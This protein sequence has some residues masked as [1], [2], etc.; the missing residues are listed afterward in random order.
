[1]SA[2]PGTTG[3]RLPPSS[4]R[5]R[6]RR[7]GEICLGL[8]KSDIV[9]AT[10]LAFPCSFLLRYVLI[11][12]YKRGSFTE[13]ILASRESIGRAFSAVAEPAMPVIQE[14]LDSHIRPTVQSV[15]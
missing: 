4:A 8:H 1:M 7:P 5:E 13:A 15:R 3:T 11:P 10:L 9:M 14:V 12:W 6:H 2:V